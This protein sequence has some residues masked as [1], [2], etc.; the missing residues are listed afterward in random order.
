NLADAK[1]S[2]LAFAVES[3]TSKEANHFVA[4]TAL[5]LMTDAIETDSYETAIALGKIADNAARK[6]KAVS[7]VASV[8]KRNEEVLTLQNQYSRIR[9]F[10][11]KIK[12]DDDDAK[13]NLELGKY[14]CMYKGNWDKGLYQMA[15]GSDKTWKLQAQRD[16]GKPTE[17][18]EQVELGNAW[19][20][21][22]DKE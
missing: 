4:E 3:L 19:W 6:A 1:L 2:A 5:G 8:G 22:G 10:A 16:L 11:D 9:P 18:N 13:S 15:L 12:K 21:L 20:N 14:Y 17:P 7:L